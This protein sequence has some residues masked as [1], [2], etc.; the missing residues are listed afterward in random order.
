MSGKQFPEWIIILFI[1][2]IVIGLVVYYVIVT[3]K[4]YADDCEYTANILETTSKVTHN[5]CLLLTE[6][7]VWLPEQEYLLIA[8][9]ECK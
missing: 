1:V 6:Q 7:G 5:G 9:A 8:A 3:N 4:Q 2:L